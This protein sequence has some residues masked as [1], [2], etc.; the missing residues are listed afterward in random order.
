MT[1]M[2]LTTQLATLLAASLTL[3]S[4]ASAVAFAQAKSD[5][6]VPGV[7]GVYAIRNA[8]IVTVTGATIERG[9]IVIRNGKIE[10]VGANIAIPKDAKITEGAGLSV[11]PGLIDSNTYLGLSEVGQGA[12]GTVDT[13]ELGDFNANMKALT[14]VNPASEL[15]PVARMNGVT[16][17]LTCPS[18][19]IISGQCAFMNLDGWTPQEMK[20]VAP[21]ALQLNYPRVGGGGRSSGGF[22]GGFFAGPNDQQRQQRERQIEA[23]RKKLEDAQAYAQAKE[24]AAKDKSLPPRAV[25]LGLEALIPVIKGEVPIFVSADGESEIKGAIELAGKYKLKLVISGGDKAIKVASL[26]KEKNIPVVLGGVLELPDSDDSAYDESYAR[27]GELHKA[28]V[29]IALTTSDTPS[30]IRLLPYHAGTAAAFGLPKEEALKAITIYPAQIFGVDKL[31][32]SIEAGKLANL[33]VT[34]GD[35]LEFRTKVKQMFIA[36]KPVD[37]SNK[38][39]R[40][41][42]KYKDRP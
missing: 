12:P 31:V 24:A 30:D 23:L 15:I 1:K 27:A 11:Y 8:K 32:G 29:K 38:H 9:T 5:P 35:I 33:V 16:T 6:G 42:E 36:G 20:L 21:A 22:G 37:L 3:V 10:A 7:P 4:L 13:T 25:D 17:V 26:L 2:K 14:A 18:G 19:G 28:G 34:D 39:T 40:L 41:Y